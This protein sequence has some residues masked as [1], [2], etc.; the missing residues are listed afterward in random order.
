MT[1]SNFN[2]F[3]LIW[4]YEIIQPFCNNP[5]LQREQLWN[6]NIVCWI[7]FKIHRSV[8]APFQG[9]GVVEST[10][11][12]QHPLNNLVFSSDRHSVYPVKTNT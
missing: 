2:E 3:V 6:N 9:A 11:M 5:A 1:A 8:Q 12:S 4:K 7:C 10:V